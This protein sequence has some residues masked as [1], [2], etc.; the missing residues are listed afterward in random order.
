MVNLSKYLGKFFIKLAD[1]ADG[2]IARDIVAVEDGNY[3]KADLL[4]NNGE[5]LSLNATNMR[6]LFK[7]FGGDPADWVGK[8]IEIFEG[9]LP[10]KGGQQPGL[11]V[12][13]INPPTLKP[14]D[15]GDC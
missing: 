3:D 15:G 11:R 14:S 4:L 5:R 13:A 1:V 12:R 6:T 10:Y 9:M 2:S 7:A 8:R